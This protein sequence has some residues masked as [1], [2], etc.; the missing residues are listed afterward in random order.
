MDVLKRWM[1]A[2]FVHMENHTGAPDELEG[3]LS[4]VAI[5]DEMIDAGY[6]ARIRRTEQRRVDLEQKAQKQ[7]E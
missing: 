6:V 7:E 5:D 2:G 4:P 1:L 3:D